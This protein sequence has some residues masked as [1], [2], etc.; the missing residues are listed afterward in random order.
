MAD[1]IEPTAMAALRVSVEE[2]ARLRAH[3]WRTAPRRRIAGERGALRFVCELGFV[4]LMPI[5]GAEL[6]SMHAATRREW[7]WWDWK[8]T[9]P[10]KRACYYG[11]LIRRRGTFVSW[12]WFPLFYA[13]YAD[14]RPYQRQYREGLL[15]RT[16]KQV[17]DLLEEGGPMMTREVRLAC[18]A[19]GKEDTRRVK[20]ALVELQGRFLIAAV[21]GDTEGWSHHR[22]D[23][24]ERW[25]PAS[26]LIEAKRVP[27][28]EARRRITVQFVANVFA[29]TPADIAWALGWER[30]EAAA[31]CDEMLSKSALQRAELPELETEAVVPNPW[32]GRE[33]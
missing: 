6:P 17:L 30:R 25:A 27:R 32:P 22:W 13:A 12:D 5:S 20:S 18:G 3:R 33:R 21:G 19:R 2:I 15:D 31:M 28:E 24:V 23:L 7:A 10:E 16:E 9:L 8:Q 1:G 4:L 26:A 11:K 29:A 14:P